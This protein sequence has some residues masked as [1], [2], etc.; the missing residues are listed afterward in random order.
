MAGFKRKRFITMVLIPPMR[1]QKKQCWMYQGKQEKLPR[2]NTQ[3]HFASCSNE[4]KK[5]PNP[6]PVPTYTASTHSTRKQKQTL[7]GSSI[8]APVL[9]AQYS[10]PASPWPRL[11]INGTVRQNSGTPSPQDSCSNVHTC[12]RPCWVWAGFVNKMGYH[13]LDCVLLRKKKEGF[14]WKCN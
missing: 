12:T 14:C 13:F 8:H 1:G 3:L 5:N 6:L 2:K 7:P 11:S 10:L 9:P 4:K